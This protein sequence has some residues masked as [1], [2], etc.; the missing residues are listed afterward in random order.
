MENEIKY[1]GEVIKVK[2]PSGMFEYYSDKQNRFLKFDTLK[3]AKES[4]NKESKDIKESVEPKTRI[5]KL[6]EVRQ[7]VK[8]ILKEG[9]QEF[10]TYHNS[11]SEAATDAREMAEKRGYVID[12]DDWLSKVAY[13]GKYGRARPAVGEY[14]TFTVGLFKDDKPQRK[15]LTFTVYGMESGKYELVAYVN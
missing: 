8:N 2:F 3:G 13:G 14:H 9:K 15:A 11:F 12:E 5:I 4:I 10:E 6:S 7:L 1:K